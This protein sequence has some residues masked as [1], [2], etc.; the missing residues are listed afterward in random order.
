MVE[1]FSLKFACSANFTFERFLMLV[2]DYD[3]ALKN[4]CRANCNPKFIRIAPEGGERKTKP[5]ATA[6]SFVF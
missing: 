6:I 4:L 2:F 5:E 1:Y 3:L